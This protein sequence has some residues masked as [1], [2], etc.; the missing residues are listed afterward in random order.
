MT[1][2]WGGRIEPARKIEARIKERA[3]A[4]SERWLCK[5]AIPVRTATYWHAPRA[6]GIEGKAAGHGRLLEACYTNG[7]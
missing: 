3:G 5:P 2:T 7:P 1:N 6:A 4:E